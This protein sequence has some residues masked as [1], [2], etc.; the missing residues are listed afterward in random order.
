MSIAH[1]QEQW[2]A[3]GGALQFY[4]GEWVGSD[5]ETVCRDLQV[6]YT[7]KCIIRQYVYLFFLFFF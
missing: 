7:Q 3:R 4:F 1:L 6:I 5:D 2:Q